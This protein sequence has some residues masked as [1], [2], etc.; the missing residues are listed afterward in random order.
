MEAETGEDAWIVFG[1]IEAGARSR[2][3]V[4]FVVVVTV[5]GGCQGLA[6]HQILCQPVRENCVQT[7]HRG[8]GQFNGTY[9]SHAN[10][11]R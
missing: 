11:K 3:S 6:S 7:T 8:G 9:S 1:W 2:I 10:L 5:R 4:G